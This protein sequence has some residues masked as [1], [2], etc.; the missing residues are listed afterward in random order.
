MRNIFKRKELFAALARTSVARA[1][2]AFGVLALGVVL[3]RLYG[4]EGVGVFAL[5]QSLAACASLLA[6]RGMSVALI[7]LAGCDHSDS[8]SW[9]IA[10]K[11]IRKTM[12]FSIAAT[13]AILVL[14]E[15]IAGVFSAPQLEPLLVPI[16][17]SVPAL[18]ISFMLAGFMKGV[19]KPASA[20]LLENGAISLTAC[21]ALLVYSKLEPHSTFLSA[22]WAFSLAAWAILVLGSIQVSFWLRITPPKTTF[23]EAELNLKNQEL[24]IASNSFFVLDVAKYS[25]SVLS[26]LIAG[27]LLNAAD[28][29]LFKTAE[30]AGML[31]GFV[32]MVINAVLP[33][34]FSSLFYNGELEA[35][36][37]LARLG[38]AMG[39]I[40]ALPLLGICIFAPHWILG[41][42]GA[43]FIQADNLLRIIAFA[44]LVNVATASVDYLLSM[45][46]HEKLIRNITVTCSLLG[47]GL[48]ILFILWFGV[49]GAAWAFALTMILQKSISVY[50]V[51]KVLGIWTLPFPNVLGAAGVRSSALPATSDI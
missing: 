1:I 27:L 37:R 24:L 11:A 42:F 9:A 13:S 21:A 43:E 19:R 23:T 46:G 51:W 2:A 5:A 41:L 8:S 14:R 15:W 31:I 18:T 44:Q 28:L 10:K 3:A 39:L 36:G 33:S 35:L 12:V 38:G 32:L 6:R 48:Y 29:G 26:V 40:L 17:L 50:F 47:I 4:A 49:V 25:Q 34:R 30:R 16:S 20:S 7:R 45:T 22:G